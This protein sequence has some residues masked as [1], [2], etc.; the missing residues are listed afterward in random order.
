[1]PGVKIFCGLTNVYYIQIMRKF[2][3]I[4]LFSLMLSLSLLSC[5]MHSVL[6]D[7]LSNSKIVEALQEALFLGSKTAANSLGI[8]CANNSGGCTTGYL[9][10]ELVEIFLPDTIKNV[11]DKIDSFTGKLDSINSLL[12]LGGSLLKPS[13]DAQSLSF[14]N[15]WNGFSDMHGLGGRIKETLNR[16]AESAAP[17]SV[18]LFKNAIFEMSFSDARSILFGND[19]IAATSYLKQM[20]FTGLQGIF[21]GILKSCLDALH[22]NNIWSPVASS[23]N[24]FANNY[25]NNSL[26]TAVNTYNSLHPGNKI[27]MPAL[28]Y[29]RLGEDL[30][31]DLSNFATG[32]ALDG[33]FYMV[34]VQESKL[35]ADPWGT[36]R[37]VSSFIT[38]AIGDLL[39][40][41]FSRAREG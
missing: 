1:M 38:D 6:S 7:D 36:V 21:G 26:S 14:G 19:S 20:T 34:G 37:A 23:Y 3:F 11:L 17:Q 30:S 35:R 15:L 2:I 25:A 8:P 16:G 5:G 22:L 13:A 10:N 4:T 18:D 12:S 29:S 32:K 39:G 31:G 40:D 24:S 28:P 27:H 41:V 9:G 33:L